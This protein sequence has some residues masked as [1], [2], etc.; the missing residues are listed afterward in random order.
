MKS[1]T[2]AYPGHLPVDESAA[3]RPMTLGDQQAMSEARKADS[4]ASSPKPV[5]CEEELSL[6]DVRRT[7]ILSAEIDQEIL[8]QKNIKNEG[9]SQ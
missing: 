2:P 6:R 4:A 1:R 3:E 8:T 9:S 7:A 5:S